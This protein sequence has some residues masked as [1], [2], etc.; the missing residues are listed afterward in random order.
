MTDRHP[1]AV[2]RLT[3]LAGAV[4]ALTVAAALLWPGTAGAATTL[5]ASAAE[6]G[7][8]F[9]TAVSAGK[10]GDAAYTTIAGREFTMATPENEMK[11]DATEPAQN[12]FSWTAADRVVSFAQSHG[13]RIRGHAL[14]WHSQQPAWVQAL[15]GAALRSAMLN[16][17]STVAAHY[18]G[19]IYSWDVVNEAFADGTSGARRDSNLQRTGN[20]W[21]EAAFRAART[22]DPGAK[23]CY[24]DYNIDSWAAAKTQ[25]VA[26]MIRDFKARG[27]PID[28]VG[29]QSHFT[30]GSSYPPDYRTT[31][32]NFAALGVDVQITELDIT[33]ANPTAYAN[34]VNDCYAVA[35]CNGITVWG[36]RDSDSWRSGESP[37]LFDG[38]GNKKPAYTSVLTALN[39]GAGGGT[40]TGCTA[41]YVQ[42][43]VFGD[44]YNSTINVTGSTSWIVTVTITPPQRISATWSA[45]VSWDISGNVMTAR[46]NGSGNS[47]GFTTMFNGNSTARPSVSCRV[48]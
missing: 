26:A 24:N 8:Y 38:A 25:A 19:V 30:G 7:R 16:H 22:A 45:A 32:A 5:G 13:M 40:G 2:A 18:R 44:R 15:S 37:L 3:S 43:T 6:H 46:P 11:W 21:I 4:A 47:F 12:T 20:D 42:G 34:V 23:L 17:V 28:C 39:A 29:L 27:V 35:R 1:H 9:G 31:L 14:A 10:L 48:G 33:N 36:V 41:T